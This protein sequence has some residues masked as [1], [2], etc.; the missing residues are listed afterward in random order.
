LQKSSKKEK[1]QQSLN[2]LYLSDLLKILVNIKEFHSN[3]KL[4]A[5]FYLNRPKDL[6]L[7]KVRKGE[8]IK[9]RNCIAH[10]DVFKYQKYRLKFIRSLM[11]FEVHLG[12]SIHKLHSLGKFSKK[13]ITSDILIALYTIKPELFEKETSKDF[14]YNKDRVLLDMFDDIAVMNGWNYNKLPSPWTIL[15]QKYDLMTTNIKE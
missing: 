12:C 4:T 3:E 1:L 8:I 14:T 10:Y 7:L 6:N 5:L 2:S 15:R 9:L 11:F 13:P